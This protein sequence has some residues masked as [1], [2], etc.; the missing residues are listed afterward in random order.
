MLP[1]VTVSSSV[2]LAVSCKRS[3]HLQP[4]T[5]LFLNCLTCLIWCQGEVRWDTSFTSEMLLSI[6]SPGMGVGPVSSLDFGVSC[7]FMCQY[8]A[9]KRSLCFLLNALFSS[10]AIVSK[11]CVTMKDA[12]A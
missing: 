5:H 7:D 6:L 4:L 8:V 11:G 3:H 9:W 10:A 2:T 1:C 12:L